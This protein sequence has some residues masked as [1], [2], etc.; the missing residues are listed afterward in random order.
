M[1][2]NYCQAC[3]FA[4]F[5]IKTRIAIPHTCG[6][7]GVISEVKYPYMPTR[8]ELDMYLKRLKE[9]MQED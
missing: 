2:R 5:G 7:K 3:S 9:L 8:E 4:K 6:T 1:R